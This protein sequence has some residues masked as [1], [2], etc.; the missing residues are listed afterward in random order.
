M[1]GSTAERRHV[2]LQ[3]ATATGSRQSAVG[4]GEARRE[5]GSEVVNPFRWAI[6]ATVLLVCPCEGEAFPR[7]AKHLCAHLSAS[8]FLVCRAGA[9]AFARGPGPAPGATCAAPPNCHTRLRWASDDRRRHL[10]RLG[11]LVSVR[12]RGVAQPGSLHLGSSLNREVG[13]SVQALPAAMAA[14]PGEE[15]GGGRVPGWSR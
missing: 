9:L 14:I 11:N 15:S 13:L 7:T 10:S 2:G 8:R 6:M 1:R 5:C 3:I 12:G 4:N